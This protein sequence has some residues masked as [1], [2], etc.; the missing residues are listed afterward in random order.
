ME[1]D[2]VSPLSWSLGGRLIAFARYVAL[3]F[4]KEAFPCQGNF[5]AGALAF[6]LVLGLSPAEDGH[7]AHHANRGM[8]PDEGQHT[9]GVEWGVKRLMRSVGPG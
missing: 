3:T 2:Y 5:A 7:A 4:T 8:V 9:G 6:D 1:E